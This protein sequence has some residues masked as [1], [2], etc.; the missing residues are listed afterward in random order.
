MRHTPAITL[1]TALL[2]G[3]SGC[4]GLLP[5]QKPKNAERQLSE[6]DKREIR[7]WGGEELLTDMEQTVTSAPKGDP[8]FAC[9]S[10][11]MVAAKYEKEKGD[12][13][14]EV[15]L[16]QLNGRCEKQ[17]AQAET[18][19]YAST[20]TKYGGRCKEKA[21]VAGKSHYL[22]QAQLA[23]DALRK[24]DSP[25]DWYEGARGTKVELDRSKQGLGPDNHDLDGM[26]AEYDRLVLAHRREIDKAKTFLDRDDILEMQSQARVLDEEL[27]VLHRRYSEHH[28]DSTADLIRVTQARRDALDER[29]RREGTKAGVM[30]D[31]RP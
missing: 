19:A 12:K 23:M 31:R 26:S 16:M 17:C 20:A 24:S 11:Y 15:A 28:W 25:L 9:L 10:G 6:Q 21:A 30:K 1:S 13:Q 5:A 4:L 22:S 3:A 2:C 8:I 29:Y 14:N 18:S 7:L 27:N